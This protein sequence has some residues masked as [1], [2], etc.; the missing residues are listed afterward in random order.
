MVSMGGAKH[1]ADVADAL[2]E[3]ASPTLIAENLVKITNSLPIWMV[4]MTP[5]Q[6][7]PVIAKLTSVYIDKIKTLAGSEKN[8]MAVVHK[9]ALL[10]QKSLQSLKGNIQPAT[11]EKMQLD[12]AS[13]GHHRP[14]SNNKRGF[15]S[16]SG[17]VVWRLAQQD[18]KG[19]C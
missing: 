18:E 8:D 7:A 1:G 14:P 9:E 6:T 10:I 2:Q 5:S 17:R 19:T 13:V 4:E 16:S 3:L 15:L 12:I 11:L